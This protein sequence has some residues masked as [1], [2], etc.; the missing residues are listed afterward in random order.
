MGKYLG[1]CACF[2]SST[3]CRYL[4]SQHLTFNDDTLAFFYA[5]LGVNQRYYRAGDEIIDSDRLFVIRPWAWGNF[6][7]KPILL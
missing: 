1:Y 6:E 7:T 2:D 5:H 4:A 3:I